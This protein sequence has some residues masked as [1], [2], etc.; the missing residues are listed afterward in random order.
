MRCS[1]W[2]GN[3]LTKL[4]RYNLNALKGPDKR[5]FEILACRGRMKGLKRE[6]VIFSIYLPPGMAGKLLTDVI[7][8]LTDDIS[9]AKAKANDPWLIV[10]G[11]FNRYDTSNIA[12]IIPDLTQA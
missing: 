1:T 3:D 9:K 12:Q 6:V 10:G 5:D 4:N 7:E 2:G 11:D 8:A